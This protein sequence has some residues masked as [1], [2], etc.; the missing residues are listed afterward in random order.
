MSDPE[1]DDSDSEEEYSDSEEQ[2]ENEEEDEPEFHR[3]TP[4]KSAL[5][6]G[7]LT[8]VEVTQKHHAKY[9]QQQKNVDFYRKIDY[10]FYPESYFEPVPTTDKLKPAARDRLSGADVATNIRFNV[11]SFL[12][13][14]D[15]AKLSATS[16]RNAKTAQETKNQRCAQSTE[17]GLLCVQGLFRFNP[18]VNKEL[19]SQFCFEN[20]R[21]T[22]RNILR[23]CLDSE[24]EFVYSTSR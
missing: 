19:C 3:F 13:A 10:A 17:F 2:E 9:L 15:V 24:L 23:L 5:R 12:P 20:R 14:T 18:Y 6:R 4:V 1:E 7:P 21:T 8:A 22:L 11:S 16:Q